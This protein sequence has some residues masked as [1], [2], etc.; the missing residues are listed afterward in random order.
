MAGLA[1]YRTQHPEYS[2]I[3]DATLSRAL[4]DKYYSD[5]MS[6]EDFSSKL[7]PEPVGPQREKYG[8]PIQNAE[9]QY[10]VGGDV[11]RFVEGVGG[12]VE[13]AMT[14][15][16]ATAGATVGGL[17][18]LGQMLNPFSDTP[19]A[20]IVRGWQEAVTYK[21][22]TEAGRR[23]LA[24][25]GPA[26]AP[27]TEF[28]DENLRTGDAT[29]EATGS[30]LLATI[31]NM[32]PEVI[33]AMLGARLPGTKPRPYGPTDKQIRKEVDVR[34]AEAAPSA[35][36]LKS[37]ATRHFNELD[38]L[39]VTVKPEKFATLVDGI[40]K[41]MIKGGMDVRVTPEA[42]GALQAMKEALESGRPLTLSEIDVLREIAR[43]AIDPANPKKAS[44]GMIPVNAI[45]D[46]LDKVTPN[47]LDFP[48]SVQPGKIGVK[49]KQARNQ[50]GRARRSETLAKAVAKAQNQAS[51]FENGLR[52]QFKQ[53]LDNEKKA[54]FFTKPEKIAMRQVV[55][56]TV[57][58][59][60]FKTLGKAG[61]D[62]NKGNT[63]GLAM[64]LGGGTW[65]AS[66][67]P[68]MALVTIGAASTAKALSTRMTAKGAKF[69]DEVVRAGNDA[70]KIAE[71]YIRNTPKAQRS[72]DELSILLLNEKTDLSTLKMTELTD[73]AVNL[74]LERR[75]K[76]AASLA[77]S[78]AARGINPLDAPR[79]RN[80]G[81]RNEGARY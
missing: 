17:A 5:K 32:G 18:G 10:Q 24:S 19:P 35:S 23:V 42:A 78:S 49:Y 48:D 37:E 61:I 12:I 54:K 40:E 53:I 45:D 13:P 67:N 39:D 21:P 74:G 2:Q 8:T 50:W 60:L 4:Y 31:N 26:L 36:T 6:F 15:G 55:N 41:S 25:Y 64:V 51:G 27:V 11:N 65:A 43:N 33:G 62:L 80:D 20:N 7:S 72:A 81:A 34:V 77:A 76:L 46:F 1:E 71:A 63:G 30:P 47:Q 28:V 9:G 56:G 69:A 52:I 75:R 38:A 66:G 29:L 3:D 68:L 59:N 73:S 79:N 70:K 57:T 44:L 58:G 22:R 14:M 16:S